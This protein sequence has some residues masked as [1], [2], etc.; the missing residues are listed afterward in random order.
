MPHLHEK[1]DFTADVFIVHENKVLLRM[2]EKYHTLLAVG[3]HVELDE[4]PATAAKRE[5]M[6]EVGLPVTLLGEY[7]VPVS[8]QEGWRY[9]PTPAGMNIHQITDTHQHV[10]LVFFA[11][12][13]H[14]NIVPEYPDD[15]W[16]WLTKDELNVRDDIRESIKS[17]ALKALDT[18]KT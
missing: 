17:Y 10:S 1:I 6:E 16:E 2:H 11:T 7:E 15:T 4:D 8:T 5:C 14:T 9:L 13:A 3:G 18:L 12:T